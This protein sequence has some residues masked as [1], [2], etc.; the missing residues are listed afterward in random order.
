MR[1]TPLPELILYGR[2]GCGLCE[3]ARGFI[4]GLLDARREAGLATP[5]LVHRDIDTNPT[6]QRAYFSSIPVVELGERR[7]EL[8]ISPAKV[9]RLLT[10]VLDA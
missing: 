6:W 10:D 4:T 9:R 7:L 5:A 3:E 1:L 8:A 2:P